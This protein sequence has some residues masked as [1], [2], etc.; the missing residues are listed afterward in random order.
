ML[1]GAMVLFSLLIATDT[2]VDAIQRYRRRQ[3]LLIT[4][5]MSSRLASLGQIADRID[6]EGL[7]HPLWP[8][9]SK[10]RH[11]LVTRRVFC[12]AP[13]GQSLLAIH[14]HAPLC[15]DPLVPSAE[16]RSSRYVQPPA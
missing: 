1:I 9:R 6:Q 2:L 15:E 14:S 8:R 16:G 12:G 7:A 11:L 13:Q 3:W 5:T 4:R 10:S